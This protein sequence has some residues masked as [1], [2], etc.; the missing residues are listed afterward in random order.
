VLVGAYSVFSPFT[1]NIWDVIDFNSAYYGAIAGI[2]RANLVLKYR[3]PWFEWSW[4]FLGTTGYG[5]S[6]DLISGSFGSLKKTNNGF[7]W[8]IRSRTTSIPGSGDGNVDYLL[9]TWDSANFNQL[10]YFTSEKVFMYVDN[11]D[12]TSKDIYTWGA[13]F[14]YFTGWEFSGQFRL[15]NKVVTAFSGS[16]LCSDSSNP[17]CDADGDDMYDEIAVNWWLKWLHNWV[18]FSILP[19]SSVF[20]YSWMKVDQNRDTMIRESVI[21]TSSGSV[22]FGKLVGGSAYRFNPIV[23]YNGN[24]L[25]KHNVISSSP[26]SM[27]TIHYNSYIVSD[28][29][30][31][32]TDL[33]PQTTWLEFSFGLVNLLHSINNNIYPFLEYKLTFGWV[34]ANRF[35]TIEWDSLVGNYNVKIIMKKSTNSDSPIWD[36]TIVF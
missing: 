24:V 29:L 26:A 16:L 13:S 15:P 5:P 36:F 3:S 11:T 34:V 12:S 17:A 6:S 4:W 25:D 1:Q 8:Q 21:N 18:S 27:N 19:N 9:A 28:W 35:Y 23:A 32:S 7:V 31:N 14:L 2:E 22:D 30:L 33:N 20:Y 10:P